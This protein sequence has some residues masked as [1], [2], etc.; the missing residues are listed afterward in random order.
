MDYSAFVEFISQALIP[1]PNYIKDTINVSGKVPGSI[2][3]FEACNSGGANITITSGTPDTITQAAIN[4][5][6]TM[7]N[8][9][10]DEDHPYEW[11]SGYS[12]GE[13]TWGTQYETRY[14]LEVDKAKK[15]ASFFNTLDLANHIRESY[16]DIAPTT[17][18][19]PYSTTGGVI[20]ET[21]MKEFLDISPCIAT[22]PEAL[23]ING[24][25]NKSIAKALEKSEFIDNSNYKYLVYSGQFLWEKGP[26]GMFID[27]ITKFEAK[28][29]NESYS[30]Y[31]TNKE[32]DTYKQA[33]M[34]Y[35][36]TIKN[37]NVNYK[38]SVSNMNSLLN[39]IDDK[40]KYNEVL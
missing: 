2:I 1:L 8:S 10:L 29:N 32:N 17:G 36:E 30:I 6:R 20:A 12:I 27:N 22:L 38:Q 3:S 13:Y 23:G 39:S 21:L 28:I 4:D 34:G 9:I 16:E 15:I 26:R 7:L 11:P 31:S 18:G 25:V 33:L 24:A 37:I 5:A 40:Y 19:E 14:Q 35:L